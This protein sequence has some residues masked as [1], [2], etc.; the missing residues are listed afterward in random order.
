MEL[1]SRRDLVC[2]GRF[3]RRCCVERNECT[4]VLSQRALTEGSLFR[5]EL[6]Q[7]EWERE[8]KQ[9][10]S[11]E[12]AFVRDI[13]REATP[14]LVSTF[15]ISR[16]VGRALCN[17]L[18]L[19]DYVARSRKRSKIIKVLHFFNVPRSLL[20][21]LMPFEYSLSDEK[22][23]KISCSACHSY[24]TYRMNGKSLQISNKCRY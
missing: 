10:V 21:W 7:R 23:L 6:L 22:F 3:Q 8:R 9:K 4:P 15:P 2:P 16:N 11:R 14:L 17:S 20:K 24:N 18:I 13:C 19:L 12:N 5:R 1:I